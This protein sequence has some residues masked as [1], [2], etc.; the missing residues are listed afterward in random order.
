MTFN[1]FRAMIKR[2]NELILLILPFGL[3]FLEQVIPFPVVLEEIVKAGVVYRAGSWRQ[4]F[5][6][7]LLFGLSEAALYLINANLLLSLAG[8]WLRLIIT[9]PM[10]GFSAA[11]FYRYKHHWWLGLTAAVAVHALFN[12]TVLR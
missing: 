6:W 10:H 2:M 12:L 3:W 1:R 8:W 7:G 11:V 5:G 9:V 4:A